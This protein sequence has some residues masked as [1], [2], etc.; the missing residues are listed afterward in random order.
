[1][2]APNS[3]NNQ[4][5]DVV[6][7][8]EFYLGYVSQSVLDFVLLVNL[9]LLCGVIGLL[10]IAANLANLKVFLR[11]GFKDQVN[12]TLAALAVSDLGALVTLEGYNVL[13]NPWL[14]K[15]DL[16]F[17]PLEVQ[18]LAVFYPHNYFTRVR[19]FL[20]AFIAFERCLC[21]TLPLKVKTIITRKVT[22]SYITIIYFIMIINVFPNYY[23]TYYDWKNVKNRT[24][25]GI[26]YRPNKDAVFNISFF[27]TDFFIP[28]LSFFIV[29]ICTAITAWTLR[30]KLQW[31]KSVSMTTDKP[32]APQKEMK[33][34]RMITVVS[35][36]FIV[37]FLPFSMIL[38]SRAV[39]T[40][41]KINGRFWN[42]VLL[43]G[44]VAFV[45][46]TINCSIS[47]LVYYN[48]STKFREHL[49][50]LWRNTRRL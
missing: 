47:L 24:V 11:Q 19:G 28:L 46:E 25:W 16:P 8:D 3:S 50:A 12:L 26:F 49:Q 5:H 38:T 23:M 37:C 33:V 7:H 1:M 15:A 44:S 35:A 31:R 39:V 45:L 9:D 29:I 20:T 34:V 13:V 27:V 36:I 21:V 10:G 18:S 40:E 43:V 14:A 17:L 2:P 6:G 42:L 30:S 41:M 4:S 48:M 22:F 32:A